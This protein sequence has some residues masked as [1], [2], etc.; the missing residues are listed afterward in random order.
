LTLRQALEELDERSRELVALRYG[1]DLS[2]RD[3]GKLV[4]MTPNAVDVALHRTLGRLRT[5]LEEPV[6]PG[7]LETSAPGSYPKG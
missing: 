1:A 5:M 7:R 6:G 2:S 4:D 3:I